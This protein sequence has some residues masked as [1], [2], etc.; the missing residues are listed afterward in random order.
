MDLQPLGRHHAT[1]RRLRALRRDPGLR[2]AAG[3]FLAEGLH[4]AQEALRSGA[5]IELAVVAPRLAATDEGREIERRI[6]ECGLTRVEI[7]DAVMESIQDARSPQPITLLVHRQEPPPDAGLEGPPQP[8]VLA[9]VGVQDPGSLGTLVRTAD[10]AGATACLVSEGSADPY[11]PRAVR[12]TVGSIFRLP[13]VSRPIAAAIAAMRE[14]GLTLVGTDPAAGT[15][16]HRH[17]Y[18]RSTAIFVGSEGRGLPAAVRAELDELV[19]V[20]LRPGVESLSLAAAAAVVLFE[21][22][23]Q[24]AASVDQPSVL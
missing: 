18:S 22:A 3:L 20:P 16:Y 15:A 11:H 6:V 5:R 24:R 17:D 4:L 12:A 19:R 8:L 13:V 2:R 9:A 1:I 7:S 10:A 14:H 23:R 21:A